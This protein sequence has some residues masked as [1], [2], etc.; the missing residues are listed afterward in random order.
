MEVIMSHELHQCVEHCHCH[1]KEA[2]TK[3]QEVVE[4]LQDCCE[5]KPQLSEKKLPTPQ[6]CPMRPLEDV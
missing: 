5:V 6:I 1:C 3:L 2:I 4:L